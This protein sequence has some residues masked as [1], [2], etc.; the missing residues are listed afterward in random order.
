LL[1]TLE[2]NAHCIFLR[3]K[4]PFNGGV[5]V[6]SEPAHE[7]ANTSND[8]TKFSFSTV[9]LY[10]EKDEFLA[11][12]LVFTIKSIE[13]EEHGGFEGAPRWPITVTVDDGR[14]DE[15]ITLQANEKRDQQLQA[16]KAHLDANGPIHNVQLAKRGKAFYF[17]TIIEGKAL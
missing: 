17:N 4:Q 13:Y 11:K 5:Y 3:L 16:A 2:T 7:R 1:V 8:A 14:P 10:A 12:K 6:K 9:P 15:I